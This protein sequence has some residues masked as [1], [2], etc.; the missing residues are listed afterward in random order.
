MTDV[1]V[2]EICCDFEEYNGKLCF[3][4]EKGGLM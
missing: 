4:E 3:I 1:D 2:K